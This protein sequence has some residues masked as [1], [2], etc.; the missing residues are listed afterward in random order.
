MFDLQLT[1]EPDPLA[2]EHLAAYAGLPAEYVALMTRWGPGVAVA[3]I[4]FPDPREPDG[5]FALLQARYRLHAPH[6]RAM[7][8]W[9]GLDSEALERGVVIGRLRSGAALV[10]VRDAMLL[11]SPDGRSEWEH[12]LRYLIARRGYATQGKKPPQTYATERSRR[13]ELYAALAR[14]DETEADVLLAAAFGLESAWGIL[15]IAYDLA[16]AQRAIPAELRA[17][18]FDRCLRL[19]K[20]VDTDRLR[21]LPVR[22]LRDAIAADRLGAEDAQILGRVAL[23]AGPFHGEDTAIERELAG[24]VLANPR[25]RAACVVLA[26]HLETIGQ[27][28]RAGLVR[29]QA[30]A[31][32][33]AEVAERGLEFRGVDGKAALESWV[34]A[35]RKDDPATPIDAIDAL[36]AATSALPAQV[37]SAMI[38]WLGQP[39]APRLATEPGAF[40]LLLLGL[41]SSRVDDC[42]RHLVAL[43]RAAAAPFF[44][45][46]IRHPTWYSERSYY[47]S[48]RDA[49]EMLAEAYL[50]LGRLSPAEVTEVVGWTQA[51]GRRRIAAL[52]LLQRSGKDD[53]VLVAC[54]EHFTEGHPYTERAIARRKTDPR[55]IPALLAAF[56]R[57]EAASLRDG[58]TLA[59][60]TEYGI[61]SR[62]LARLGNERGKGAWE[63]FKQKGRIDRAAADRETRRDGM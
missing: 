33:W 45:A 62:Y 12:S 34:A 25:D 43:K 24:Q 37:A 44:L 11:L 39:E 5:L 58:R 22:Q 31:L 17:T 18:Y 26:D 49:L 27:T 15:E 41:R 47:H 51:P 23:T 14:G 38:S 13:P 50:Q 42:V 36:V 16:T 63:R 30:E 59:Y 1:G 21:D 7:G 53:R 40:E 60:T 54:L 48:S 8:R 20:R 6:Q 35:W 57:A 61:L 46:A 56:D 29:E 28:L 19:A 2:P 55:V 3:Q 32:P 52:C 10:A 9:T 4:E